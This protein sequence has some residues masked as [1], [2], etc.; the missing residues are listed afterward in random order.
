MNKYSSLGI[1]NECQKCIASS[2]IEQGQNC[3]ALD[4]LKTPKGH[5]KCRTGSSNKSC[6]FPITAVNCERAAAGFYLILDAIFLCWQPLYFKVSRPGWGHIFQRL[7]ERVERLVLRTFVRGGQFG[8]ECEQSEDHDRE[9]HQ[10]VQFQLV[11]KPDDA[12]DAEN[13]VVHH[14]GRDTGR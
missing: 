11:M 4:Q 1:R 6:P 10:F 13:Y 7:P 3:S 12:I 9:V 8:V 2:E 14:E 5:S